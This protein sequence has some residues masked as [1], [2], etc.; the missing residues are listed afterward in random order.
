[1]NIRGLT[2]DCNKTKPGTLADM[3]TVENSVL[4]ALTETW[5]TPGHLD[6]EVRIPGFNIHRADR[7][8]KSHGGAALYVRD[9]ISAVPIMTYSNG[10]VEAIVLKIREM[11]AIVFV[12]YRPPASTLRDLEALLEALEET[13]MFAQA[14]SSKFSNILGFGDYNFPQI[15]WGA[16]QPGLA[17]V[18]ITGA[19]ER[20]LTFIEDLFL[21]QTVSEV[22]RGHNTLD[23]VLTNFPAM[24]SHTEV[25]PNIK[26]SDHSTIVTY[27]SS[28][29]PSKKSE[30]VLLNRGYTSSIPNFDLSKSTE[31]D[32]IRFST[33][34]ELS[35]WESD[36]AGR[37]LEDKITHLTEL[38]E[39]AVAKVF[40]KKPGKTPGN[41][42]PLSMR[43]LMTSRKKISLKLLR[44]RCPTALL[45]MRDELIKIETKI[46]ESHTK[47]RLKAEAKVTKDIKSNPAAFYKYA[48]KFSKA[49]VKVGPLLD[50]NDKHTGDEE[51]MADI[52]GKHYATMYSVPKSSV[53]EEL[54]ENT[55]AVDPESLTPT[56][57]DI[58][59]NPVSVREALGALS[60]AAAPGPDGVPSLC[61]KRGGTLVISALVDIFT[62]SMEEGVVDESM[63][64][65]FITPIYKGGDRALPVN[66]RPVAL[67]THLTKTMERVI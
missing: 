51:A 6:S 55:F 37:S 42:I 17:E 39:A 66:Y 33:Y 12:V 58:S 29:D 59:F 20:F 41:R 21:T 64:R 24:V 60:N 11:E 48:A 13:I 2:P 23:L 1:V 43:K 53:S 57:T 34:L 16:S 61:L 56:L 10:G 54:I 27:L 19:A 3:A 22:T 35:D 62:H 47:T 15:K 4:I 45:R 65:A 52:L 5:L 46:E 14:H 25:R 30:K 32:W 40:P 67:S 28:T 18:V 31:E 49:P 63:R 26:L 50:H 36:T 8:G 44:T 7:V 38:L 9:D